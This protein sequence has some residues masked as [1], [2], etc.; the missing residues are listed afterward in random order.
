MNN[1]NN[2]NNRDRE[3][4]P[5]ML[6]SEADDTNSKTTSSP[7]TPAVTRRDKNDADYADLASA[8][9]FLYDALERAKT[10]RDVL[11]NRTRE[12]STGL[13]EKNAA[14]Q[15]LRETQDRDARQLNRKGEELSRLRARARAAEARLAELESEQSRQNDV[16]ADLER[17]TKTLRLREEGYR[18]EL[19]EK[20]TEIEV[21]KGET[22]D[23]LASLREM[24][25]GMRARLVVEWDRVSEL[26]GQTNEDLRKEIVQ[27]GLGCPG[28]HAKALKRD[29]VHCLLQADN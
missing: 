29:L 15:A 23:L 13:R 20:T 18:R 24:R 25:E 1:S 5:T 4:T 9:K 3:A 17:S 16:V 12:Q 21:L 11:L 7:A 19:E 2:D 26:W 28:E 22:A 10:S 27:R 14:I 8:N 6:L